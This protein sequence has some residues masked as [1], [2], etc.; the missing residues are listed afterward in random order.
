MLKDIRSRLPPPPDDGIYRME[1]YQPSPMLPVD[2]GANR[3]ADVVDIIEL[4]TE[5][6]A[7]GTV[8]QYTDSGWEVSNIH[9][10][11]VQLILKAKKD[12]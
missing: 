8:K 1:L 5:S 7:N 6:F 4:K 3:W 10:G 11:S 2:W 12:P 9:K